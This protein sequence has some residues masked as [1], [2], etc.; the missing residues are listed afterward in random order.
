VDRRKDYPRVPL[1]IRSSGGERPGGSPP[2][3]Q[4]GYWPQQQQQQPYE[5]ERERDRDRDRGRDRDRERPP[6]RAAREPRP[7]R[8]PRSRSR[9][10]R[11]EVVPTE[12][13]TLRNPLHLAD[14]ERRAEVVEDQAELTS[15]ARE[16]AEAPWVIQVWKIGEEYVL[17][18]GFAALAAAVDA[19]LVE[20]RVVVAARFPRWELLWVSPQTVEG[21]D[22]LLSRALESQKKIRTVGWVFPPLAVTMD[23]TD[24]YALGRGKRAAARLWAA[25]TEKLDL[26]PIVVR[27]VPRRSVVAGTVQVEVSR[28]RITMTRHLRKMGK[29]L[30]TRLLNEVATGRLRPIRVRRTS[31][32]GYELVD[33]LLRLRAA[34]EVGIRTIQA[35]IEVDLPRE[36]E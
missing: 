15:K 20:V 4:P 24:H 8:E 32:G 26:I 21:P 5:R 36:R 22:P 3:R 7:P 31:D 35:I 10:P 25:Q 17:A 33:G 27:P 29:P 34:Q 11:Y 12:R 19:A 23:D 30:P 13:I 14:W 28:V 16:S 2:Y 1:W 6:R 9:P 18:R